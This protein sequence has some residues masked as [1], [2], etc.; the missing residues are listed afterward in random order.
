MPLDG[1][2]MDQMMT[3]MNKGEKDARHCWEDSKI[4]GCV[5]TDDQKHWDFVNTIMSKFVQTNALHMDEYKM[6]TKMEAEIIR[7]VCS[8]YNGDEKSCGVLTSGGTESILLAMVAYR[9]FGLTKGIKK[10]NIVMS[11]A[12]H[13]AFDKAAFLF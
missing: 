8:M 11:N 7:M 10:P 4:S 12:A 3:F 6:I 13:A 5:Y 9:E 1:M 2:P